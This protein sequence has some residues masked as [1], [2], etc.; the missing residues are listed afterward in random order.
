MN[1]LYDRISTAINDF[2]AGRITLEQY[3]AVVA[4]T[5]PAQEEVISHKPIEQIVNVVTASI[6]TP[7]PP[8]VQQPINPPTT[9]IVKV[10]EQAVPGKVVRATPYFSK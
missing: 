5:A 7:A 9:A 2:R 1:N 8:I 6:E 10:V 3:S 4:G